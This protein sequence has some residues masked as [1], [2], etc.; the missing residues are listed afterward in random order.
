MFLFPYRL[1]IPVSLF[2]WGNRLPSLV[3][4]VHNDSIHQKRRVGHLL[5]VVSGVPDEVCLVQLKSGVHG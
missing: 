4:F 2:S 1:A 5:V 3:K